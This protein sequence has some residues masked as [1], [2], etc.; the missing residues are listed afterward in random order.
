MHTMTTPA[1]L[2]GGDYDIGRKDELKAELDA[3]SPHSDVVIDLANTASLDCFSL[4]IMVSKL[5]EWRAEKP[6]TNLRL[7]NV[8]RGVEKVMR[9]LRLERIFIIE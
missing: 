3:I 6:G 4:G 2:H 1:A 5:E 8:N 7:L 9:S